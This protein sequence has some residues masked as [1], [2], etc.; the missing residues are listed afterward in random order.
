[1]KPVK[2]WAAYRNDHLLYESMRGTRGEVYRYIVVLF[3]INKVCTM[4][5]LGIKIHKVAITKVR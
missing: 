5:S 1:M 4:K 2:C 3:G